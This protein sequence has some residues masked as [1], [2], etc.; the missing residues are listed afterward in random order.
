MTTAANK[1]IEQALE[2][3]ADARISLV[4]KLLAS[5][6][7]PAQPEIDQL[8]AEEAERRV[9]GIDR[10]KVDLIPL[11]KKFSPIYAESMSDEVLLPPAGERATLAQKRL[12][13]PIIP[14]SRNSVP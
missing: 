3:P 7:P 4:D 2:F 1:V 9:A 8:W 12:P 11:A 6:N 13:P 14:I 5:L 10:G